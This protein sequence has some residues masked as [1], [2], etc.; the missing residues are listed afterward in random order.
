[1]RFGISH[2]LSPKIQ[3]HTDRLILS[4]CVIAR[5][6]GGSLQTIKLTARVESCAD[7]GKS[8]VIMKKLRIKHLQGKLLT[9]HRSSK[10]RRNIYMPG[11]SKVD[12]SGLEQVGKC[13]L[14]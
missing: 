14:W 11:N 10:D 4:L 2:C 7:C 3:Q 12:I 8:V 13:Q 5:R 1:M 6:P 9:E